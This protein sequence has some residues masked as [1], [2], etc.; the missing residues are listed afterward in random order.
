MRKE[1]IK[2]NIVVGEFKSRNEESMYHILNLSEKMLKICNKM[3]SSWSGSFAGYHARLYFENYQVP[4]IDKM[5]D[6]EWGGLHGIPEGWQDKTAE[7]I[8]NDI[9]KFVGE[10]F[11][12]DKFEKQVEELR[13]EAKQLLEDILI[14]ISQIKFNKE[15]SREEDLYKIIEKYE[16]GESRNEFIK[17]NMPNQMASRDS[18]ALLQG[19]ILPSHLY[20]TGVAREGKSLVVSL[21]ELFRFV[22]R[23]VKQM[24]V[25]SVPIIG[26]QEKT[27]TINDLIIEA[28]TL[29]KSSSQDYHAQ[30]FD[31]Y[32]DYISAYNKLS[33]QARSFGISDLELV[34]GVP[35]DEKA[36]IG[37]G[38]VAEKA[39]HREVVNKSGILLK[40]LNLLIPSRK[41]TDK[42]ES[43]E[44][45]FNKFHI[46]A[47]QLCDRH[48]DR[49]TII[50]NDEY[51][52]QDLLHSLL[53]LFFDDIRPE[54]WTPSY[55]GSSSR[56][57]F[58]LKDEN[59]VVE[60]KK[61]RKGLGA[62][63]VGD[64]LLIDLSRYSEYKDCKTLICFIYDPDG[65]IKNP[66]GIESDLNKK[67][68]GSLKIST[69]IRPTGL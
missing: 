43:L 9:E 67:S 12:I 34:E 7:V 63:E 52:V 3:S 20:Y 5:F 2:V 1:L 29:F 56:M 69:Y 37:V 55:A 54:E 45:I 53:K 13:K 31:S 6:V 50:I 49:E 8:K 60:V 4:P 19:K 24:D 33:V 64:Q 18:R 39:K 42:I 28:D 15:L 21:I 62:K 51:D 41:E 57:D 47:K 23:F 14:E 32:S 25:K 46:I 61:T 17:N 59:I 27:M 68:T 22:E 58:L 65:L 66:R 30:R 11:E 48:G 26:N 10:S 35:D 40:K 36:T 38:T 44:R 16:F